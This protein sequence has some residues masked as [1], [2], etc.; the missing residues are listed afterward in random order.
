MANILKI[1]DGQDIT[2]RVTAPTLDEANIDFD[3]YDWDVEIVGSKH[4][5]I[6]QKRQSSIKSCGNIVASASTEAPEGSTKHSVLNIFAKS[7]EI[8]FGKGGLM[9]SMTIY[10]E[11]TNFPDNK[12]VLKTIYGDIPV[13]LI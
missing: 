11:N 3:E 5:V 10:C 8:P 9:A 7:S 13:I 12:Q 6:M 4:N 1:R 2:L